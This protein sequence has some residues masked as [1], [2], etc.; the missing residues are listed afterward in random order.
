MIEIWKT[1]IE[2]YRNW[3]NLHTK[4]ELAEF[5][6]RMYEIDTIWIQELEN[7]WPL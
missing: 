5:T 6:L 3:Y 2:K 4:I 1:N 7:F